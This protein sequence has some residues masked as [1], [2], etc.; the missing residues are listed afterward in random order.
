MTTTNLAMKKHRVVSLTTSL[1]Y[2]A[3]RRYIEETKPDPLARRQLES[4]VLEWKD[5]NGCSDSAAAAAQSATEANIGGNKNNSNKIDSSVLVDADNDPTTT[6]TVADDGKSCPDNNR[7][8]LRGRLEI[9]GDYVSVVLETDCSWTTTTTP[10]HDDAGGRDS[11]N[12]NINRHVDGELFYSCHVRS[13]RL[14]LDPPVVP[15]RDGPAVGAAPAP[16]EDDGADVDRK[17]QA[18]IRDRTIARLRQDSYISKLLREEEPERKQPQQQPRHPNGDADDDAGGG[19]A[20]ETGPVL[21]TARIRVDRNRNVLE[22][23]VDVTDSLAEALRRAVWP[24]AESS[25]DVVELILALPS[26]PCCATAPASSSGAARSAA[27]NTTAP[28]RSTTTTTTTTTTPLA[29]RAKLRM[30]ED[31]MLDACE[32]EGEDQLLEDLNL[33]TDKQNGQT[34]ATTKSRNEEEEEDD[35][36]GEPAFKRKKSESSR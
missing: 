16:Q 19:S 2:D 29:N 9:L 3:V 5:N 21:A 32:R 15:T 24:A 31:A 22:E 34:N 11:G 28:S 12:S 1:F 6:G 27:T 14:L 35:G 25:L 4:W 17:V 30:L 8:A 18:K 13:A 10:P 20:D 36:A 7:F 26:L 23:R 33:A